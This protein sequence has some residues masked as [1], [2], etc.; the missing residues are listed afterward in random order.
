[1]VTRS[2]HSQNKCTTVSIFE[3]QM[4]NRGES[5]FPKIY[6]FPFQYSMLKYFVLKVII[7]GNK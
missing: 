7:R 3:L 6:S 1:M 5:V 2:T 4:Q